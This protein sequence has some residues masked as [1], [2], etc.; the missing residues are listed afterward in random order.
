M[1]PPRGTGMPL[2]PLTSPVRMIGGRRFDFARE[3][4]IMAIVNRTPDSFFDQG[5]DFE[6]DRAVESACAAAAAGADWV[7][8]GGVPFSPDTPPVGEAEELDRVLPV[9]TETARRSSVVI[10][11]DTWRPEVAR[12]AIAAGASVINDTSG[13]HDQELAEVVAGSAATLVVTH[14]RAAPGQHLR[15]PQYGDVVTEVRQFLADRVNLAIGLGVPEDRIVI[16]PGHDLNKN[17]QHSLELTRRLSE[18]AR[19]GLP[20]LAAVSNKDFI[21]EATGL[22]KPDRL[23]PS[24]AAAAVCA[25]QGARI[26][27]M[28]DAAAAAAAATMIE[29]IAGFTAPVYERHNLN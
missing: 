16:D 22:D 23:A 19:L 6:L 7:D 1:T 2:P 21:G 24:I 26:L 5:R 8:I 4:A 20:L 11:V 13:L 25:W 17:T 12:R 27:R 29:T 14:S 10:S 18:I 9:I 28:H 3:I 15:R